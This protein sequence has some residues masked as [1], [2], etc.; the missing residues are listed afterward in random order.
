MFKR[1]AGAPSHRAHFEQIHNELHRLYLMNNADLAQELMN[2][3]RTVRLKHPEAF[4]AARLTLAPLVVWQIVP[5]LAFRLG[6]RDFLAG[7]RENG[8]EAMAAPEFRSSSGYIIVSLDPDQFMDQENSLHPWQL[9]ARRPANGNPIVFA[10]DRVAPATPAE[11][12]TDP[13]LRGILELNGRRG[14]PGH[15]RWLPDWERRPEELKRAL[16]PVAQQHL[17]QRDLEE[18]D[19]LSV[20]NELSAGLS[21]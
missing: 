4:D 8:L 11:E 15:S 3:A 14:Y 13:I 19:F 21:L 7:E 16:C 12:T 9:L 5:E 10:L 6:H 18:P 2:L 17:L 1:I 20:E